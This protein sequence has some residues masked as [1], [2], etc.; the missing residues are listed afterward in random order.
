[1]NDER[2]DDER[3]GRIFHSTDPRVAPPTF[4]DLLGRRRRAPLR[5]AIAFTLVTVVVAAIALVTGQQLSEFRQRQA[6]SS[7]GTAGATATASA[8]TSQHI[9]LPQPIAQPIT[10][11]SAAAQV[12]WIGTSASGSNGRG[13]YVGVDPTGKVIGTLPMSAGGYFRSADGA[14]VVLVGDE[15][16]A[17]SA[18]DGKV[19]RSYGNLGN[20]KL[21]AGSATAAAFSPDGRWMAI[22]SSSAF[23]EL[24]DLQTG[25]S[26][27]T[28]I[29][30]A[31]LSGAGSGSTLLFSSDSR[32]LYTILNWSG[33]L[34]L[35]DFDVASSGLTQHASAVDG[36]NGK[37]LPACGGPGLTARVVTR[38]NTL[39]LFCYADATV[40]FVDLATMTAAAVVQGSMANPFWLAP[41]FTPDDQLLYL[42]QYAAFGDLMQVIDLATRTRLGPIPTPKQVGDPGPFAWLFPVAYAGGTAST[43]PVSP[44]GLKLY[45]V[46]TTGVMVLRV[47]DLKPLATLAPGI[48]L[49]EVWVSGDGKTLYGTTDGTTVYVIAEDGSQLAKVDLPNQAGTFLAADRG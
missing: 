20:G 16:T 4:D 10:R 7:A 12:A 40:S 15:I 17:Y 2:I 27:I 32:H 19:E 21:P 22:L 25:S 6:E 8:G 33:P 1:V 39:V 41:I 35:T 37:K 45:S 44:D 36:Q 18:L 24:L 47:P 34:R 9:T 49:N 3:I 43:I 14:H 30:G 13:S 42:H 5:S 23:V 46:G 29:S 11:T 26:S 28:A 31:S 38:T 48:A